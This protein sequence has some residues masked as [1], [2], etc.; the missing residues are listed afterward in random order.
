MFCSLL[1]LL[2]IIFSG[3]QFATTAYYINNPRV[4][5]IEVPVPYFIEVFVRRIRS[6]YVKTLG[7]CVKVSMLVVSCCRRSYS[8]HF[9][10]NKIVPCICVPAGS[11]D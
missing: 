9:A 7:L 8:L 10:V 1:L 3:K 2:V 6:V 11:L 4:I 5:D